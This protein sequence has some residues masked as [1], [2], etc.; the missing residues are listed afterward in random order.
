VTALTAKNEL[1][2][3]GLEIRKQWELYIGLGCDTTTRTAHKDSLDVLPKLRSATAAFEKKLVDGHKCTTGF[4]GTI[5]E[6]KDLLSEIHGAE[7]AKLLSMI[8]TASD[9]LESMAGGCPEDSW[10]GGSTWKEELAPTCTFKEAVAQ[11]E[12]SLFKISLSKL[13]EKRSK[14]DQ[15]L[16]RYK[17][18]GCNVDSHEGALGE[19]L[20]KAVD[21]Y[22]LAS[23]TRIEGRVLKLLNKAWTDASQKKAS[24]KAVNALLSSL[25][26]SVVP[27]DSSC[28]LGAISDEVATR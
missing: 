11:A 2:E 10:T 5:V 27:I 7:S 16:K 28:I 14:L 12:K 9:L 13:E 8:V 21:I 15:A 23:T 1:F 20:Q 3:A 22:K 6:A 4:D 26:L 24:V 19:H 17:D 18:F 25:P